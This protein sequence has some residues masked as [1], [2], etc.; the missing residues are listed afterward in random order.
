MFSERE[1]DAPKSCADQ[2]FRMPGVA[3]G[4][5]RCRAGSRSTNREYLQNAVCLRKVRPSGRLHRLGQF[6]A[7]AL[8]VILQPF[9]RPPCDASLMSAAVLL[10]SECGSKDG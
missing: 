6:G 9:I 2:M 10:A 5:S 4:F 3:D 7:A 8:P 1:S